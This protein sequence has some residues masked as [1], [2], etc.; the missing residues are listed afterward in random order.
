MDTVVGRRRDYNRRV[1][2]GAGGRAGVRK[3][4]SVY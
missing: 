1:K 4:G 3:Y 2:A